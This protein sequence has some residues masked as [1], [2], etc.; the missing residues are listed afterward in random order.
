MIP[1]PNASVLL[2]AFGC[3]LFLVSLSG[4]KGAKLPSAIIIC[5]IAQ[6]IMFVFLFLLHADVNYIYRILLLLVTFIIL[7]LLAHNGLLIEF[8]KANNALIALQAVM[9]FVAFF[10]IL[11]NILQPLFTFVNVGDV[12]AYCY[13][14]TCTGAVWGNI[15]RVAGYFDEPGAFAFWGIY[16][17]II[18]KLFVNNKKIEWCI[19]IGLFATWSMAYYIQIALYFVLFY[20]NKINYI[21]PF[22]I[23][24]IIVG[25][26]IK[27]NQNSDLAI[28]YDFTFNR[29]EKNSSG[30]IETN[31][32]EMT[33]A[34]KS[35]FLSSPL[36]GVGEQKTWSIGY[37][38][39][40]PFEPL[41]KDG[42]IGTIFL[43]LPLL[44]L[45][46]DK[47]RNKDI[48]YAV[49]ILALG[50]LQRPLH[51]NLMHYLMLYLFVVLSYNQMNNSKYFI[52]ENF[53]NNS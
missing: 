47:K 27:S 10:L 6:A 42:I 3:A 20:R 23:A 2:V 11:F 32:D 50:Y 53:G 19:I 4:K 29:F 24:I 45:L 43:Y 49:F 36:F 44:L 18:N 15:C 51:G 46:L 39:D 12:P 30:T 7:R 25:Q 28:L 22:V 33:D 31:R 9:G 26:F 34:A 1:L 8:A 5:F 14:L 35:A 21:L 13:G 37:L 17:L 16:S 41:A 48:I 52:N 40:N 38:D